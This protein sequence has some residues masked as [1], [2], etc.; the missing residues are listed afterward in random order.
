MRPM[1]IY[2]IRHGET[3]GNRHGVVQ[4]PEVPLNELGREQARRLGRRLRDHG[5]VRILASDLERARMTA[6]P[7]AAQ[8]GVVAEPE[9]LLQERNFGDLRGQAY[10][11]FDFDPMGPGYE[12]PSGESWEVFYER[13]ASAWSR[14]VE[15]AHETAGSLAVVTHGLVCHAFALDHLTIEPPVRAPERWGNTSV[16]VIEARAPWR[17]ELLNCTTHL[18]DGTSDDKDARSGL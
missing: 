7:V 13:A 10:S 9:P 16:T 4:K 8:T 5:I 11:S 14:V 15:V 12:P 2:L 1:P 6:A 18:D 3:D 17:V